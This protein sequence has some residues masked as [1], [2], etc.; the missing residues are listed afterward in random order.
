MTALSIAAMNL[1]RTLRQRTNVFFVVLFPLLMIMVLGLAFG[2]QTEPR[3]AVVADTSAPLASDL[4]ASLGGAGV[5]T[6]AYADRAAAVGAVETGRVESAL[7]I[8]A[9][10]DAR[11]A[12]G[13]T[14]PVEYLSRADRTAQQV[15]MIVRSAVDEQAARVR[16]ARTL[17][18]R[19]GGDFAANLVRGDAA[20]SSVRAIEVRTATVGTA[21]FP[22]DLG[23][24]DLGASGQLLLFIFITSMTTSAALIETRQ[25][26]VARRM[27]AAPI[28]VRNI[29]AGEALGRI[30]VAVVQGTVIML[31][32]ALLF[33]VAWGQPLAA[34]L[35]MTAFATVAG[36]A[37][38]LLGSVA[39]TPQQAIATGLLVG[40]G[41]SALGGSMMPLEFFSP[42]LR[43]V[44]HVTPHAWAAD[45][46][47]ALVRHD[48]TVGDVLLELAVL[49]GYAAVLFAAASWVLRR[50][51]LR[52]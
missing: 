26:G 41:L 37:G 29:L 52:P 42:T 28:H 16:V 9:E 45:G 20:A 19:L 27:L 32:A 50:R 46:F 39:R 13:D 24:F 49:V 48:G 11:L 21:V 43:A 2:G 51:L 17:Q 8:P 3:V 22:E 33:G 44:A 12:A 36:A 10:Y 25:L 34:V 18:D 40:I 14:A 23:R 47:A 1:R 30:A 5:E 6:V 4:A 31:G 38:M 35:L 7:V 15:A